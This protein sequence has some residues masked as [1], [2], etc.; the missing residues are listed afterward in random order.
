LYT[1]I[2]PSRP[3]NNT[4]TPEI[5]LS[6]EFPVISG[7]KNPASNAKNITKYTYL[8]PIIIFDEVSLNVFF[9]FDYKI[10]F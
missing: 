2:A 7:W 5:T 1:K 6:N 10:N 9:E 4:T 8:K 3:T